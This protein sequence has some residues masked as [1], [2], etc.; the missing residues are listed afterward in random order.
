MPR[1]LRGTMNC[2]RVHHH[3]PSVSQAAMFTMVTC[4]TRRHTS[5]SR[6]AL[7]SGSTSMSIEDVRL[8]LRHVLLRRRKFCGCGRYC[9]DIVAQRATKLSRKVS[10][11]ECKLHKSQ[12]GAHH[13]WRV[14]LARLYTPVKVHHVTGKQRN[15][16]TPQ[17][18]SFTSTSRRQSLTAK[19][20]TNSAATH[21][22]SQDA[23]H[24]GGHGG[25]WG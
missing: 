1:L 5:G 23:L 14:P 8:R 6:C 21:W 3:S 16:Q 17:T 9:V 22:Q 20:Q 15:P 2:G 7:G 18:P 4:F 24:L 11:P 19:V 13:L 12:C 25:H 10:V